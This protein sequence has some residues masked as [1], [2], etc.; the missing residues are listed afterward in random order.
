MR[1]KDVRDYFDMLWNDCVPTDRIRLNI[2]YRQNVI[3]IRRDRINL[4]ILEL[5]EKGEL[6]ILYRKWWLDMGEC[7]S[8]RPEVLP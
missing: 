6:D 7:T 8:S 1:L 3:I 4:A 5:N 2:L